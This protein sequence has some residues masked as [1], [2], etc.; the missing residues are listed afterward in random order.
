M[1]TAREQDVEWN[2]IQNKRQL[3]ERAW[4]YFSLFAYSTSS[5]LAPLKG[6]SRQGVASTIQ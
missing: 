2:E 3:P 1:P 4:E 6:P 5:G